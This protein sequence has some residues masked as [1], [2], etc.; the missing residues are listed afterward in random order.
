MRILLATVLGITAANAGFGAGLVGTILVGPWT[1]SAF[2]AIHVGFAV[3]AIAMMSSFVM[4]MRLRHQNEVDQS[5]AE[6]REDD[7]AA[8]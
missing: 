4:M 7:T 8:R 1:G 6:C 5:Y 3:G 2:P